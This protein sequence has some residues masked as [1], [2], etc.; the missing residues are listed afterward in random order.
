M[1]TT[2]GSHRGRAIPRKWVGAMGIGRLTSVSRAQQK[3]A[4]TCACGASYRR[5]AAATHSEVAW[6]FDVIPL[7]LC[8]RVHAAE[9]RQTTHVCCGIRRAQ[10]TGS[11]HIN[12]VHAAASGAACASI[13]ARGRAYHIFFPLPFLPFDKRLFLPTAMFL[14]SMW[15][16]LEHVRSDRQG[17]A[18]AEREACLVDFASVVKSGKSYSPRRDWEAVTGRQGFRSA[19]RI[20]P[21]VQLPAPMEGALRASSRRS[22]AQHRLLSPSAMR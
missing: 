12:N 19:R 21:P 14:F 10:A 16:A 17:S 7:F 13:P 4:L 8:E 2:S 9:G 5:L 15:Q 11:M 22:E 20:A 18:K 6:C 3:R 1:C